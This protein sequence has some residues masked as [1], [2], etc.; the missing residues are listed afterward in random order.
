MSPLWNK[1]RLRVYVGEDHLVLCQVNGRWRPR[2][3]HKEKISVEAG[4]TSATLA[5]LDTWLN[6][7]PLPTDIECVLGSGHVRYLL[8]PWN[9]DLVDTAFRET[10]AHALFS[11]SFQGDSTKY[12]VR[13]SPARYNQPQLAAFVEKE[14]LA[15]FELLAGKF[16][17]RVVCMEPLLVSVWNRFRGQLERESGTL[18]IAEA[19]RLLVL[20][21]ANGV[22]N[23][24]QWRPCV[25]EE[26]AGRI[27][28]LSGTAPV[29]VFAPLRADLARSYPAIW[30]GLENREGF[31]AGTD[32][33]YAYALCG[34]S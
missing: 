28:Q 31:S 1:P 22:L 3:A 23:D 5:A 25:G 7:H 16:G 21:H 24:V 11:R 8:L 17:C 33:A 6:A 27:K 15:A 9:A 12:E 13:F 29:R 32:G 4:T 2:I 20:R 26:L 30:L 34:V 19:G 18:L 14:W 10:L